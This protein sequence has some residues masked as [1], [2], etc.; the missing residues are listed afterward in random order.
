MQ[1]ACQCM[2]CKN[3]VM[4]VWNILWLM[5]GFIFYSRHHWLITKYFFPDEPS[6]SLRILLNTDLQEA[7]NCSDETFG[8]LLSDYTSCLFTH[9]KLSLSFIMISVT[10]N[11]QNWSVTLYMASYIVLRIGFAWGKGWREPDRSG[12]LKITEEISSGG[13]GS[14]KYHFILFLIFG[15][16]WPYCTAVILNKGENGGQISLKNDEIL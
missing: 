2:S 7:L 3:L 5:Y 11:Y 1:V 15:M 13:H 16:I 14:T 10:K 8:Q 9:P 6:Y 4:L 12:N